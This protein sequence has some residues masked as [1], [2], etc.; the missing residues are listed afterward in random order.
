MSTHNIYFHGEIRKVY[1]DTHL[2][3]AMLTG[4]MYIKLK[5]KKNQANRLKM[6]T[7]ITLSIRSDRHVQ[8]VQTQ[9]LIWIYFVYHSSSNILHTSIGRRKYIFKF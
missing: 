8:T 7:V 5:K 1:A 3:G 2:S 6:D 4:Y 9:H